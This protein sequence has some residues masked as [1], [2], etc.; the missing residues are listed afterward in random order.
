MFGDGQGTVGRLW[1]IPVL[2]I[3]KV[4]TSARIAMTASISM[5]VMP[6]SLPVRV[7]APAA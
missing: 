6:R 3:A 2:G 5:R 1:S 4:I 7:K